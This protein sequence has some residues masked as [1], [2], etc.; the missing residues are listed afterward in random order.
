MATIT[1]LQ[2]AL[3]I[4]ADFNNVL[5]TLT[6]HDNTDYTE[7]Q[8]DPTEVSLLFSLSGPTG[9][10]YINTGFALDDISSPDISPI[11]SLDSA[12]IDLPL[13]TV[14]KIAPGTYIF[15]VKSVWNSEVAQVVKT[16]LFDYEKPVANI[17]M[18]ADVF[19][20]TITATDNT[21]YG[22][23]ASLGIT[24]II[25][26][27]TL[28]EIPDATLTG[29]VVTVGP[30]IW[31]KTWTDSVTSEVIWDDELWAQGDLVWI[32]IIDT[33][34]GEGGIDVSNS[35]IGSMYYQAYKTINDRLLSARGTRA[36]FEMD[37]LQKLRDD[38]VFYFG[39]YLLAERSGTD[40][41][42]AAS[43]IEELIQYEGIEIIV[44]DEPV[45]ILP[46]S[47]GS[48]T[49]VGTGTEW[50]SAPG[51][52]SPSVGESGDFYLDE[53][54]PNW[55]YKKIGGSWAK[56]LYMKGVTG[57][58]GP[59]GPTGVGATGPTGPT[60]ATG[61]SGPRGYL[62]IQGVPG[63]AGWQLRANPATILVPTDPYGY[64]GDYSK[65]SS[66]IELWDGNT[67]VDISGT[68]MAI[69]ADYLGVSQSVQS[70][71]SQK[72]RIFS[73]TGSY[74]GALV[75]KITTSF[76]YGGV[77][78][79]LEIPVLMLRAG[80]TG[81]AGPT[82]AAGIGTIGAQ[83]ITG[84]T[85]P[86]GASIVG[87]T[88]ARGATGPTGVGLTGPTGPTGA[89]GDIF[90]TTS[91]QSKAIPTSHPT[92]V[93]FSDV[94]AALKYSPGQEIIAAN[95][96]THYFV[97]TVTTYTGTTLTVSSV[98]NV[99]T[100]TFTAWAINMNGAP[101]PAGATGATGAAGPT[102]PTGAS[103]IG[104]TGPT[105]PTGIQGITGPTGPAGPTGV[106]ITGP[107]GPTG[108]T[109]A[110]GPTTVGPTGPTGP[111]SPVPGQHAA[112]APSVTPEYYGQW[113]HN[114]TNGDLYF[115]VG[116]TSADWHL[117]YTA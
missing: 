36:K 101:G 74:P 94:S 9:V 27:P 1:D 59:A 95:D 43:K 22:D 70:T 41:S 38:L 56:L 40:S 26:A 73:V 80:L 65:A 30:S 4:R 52:P 61:P 54:S 57:A 37:R 14:G 23:Y 102:G 111:A 88:G 13:N 46:I 20:S 107:T 64:S 106:G 83:G 87:P 113:Y 110:T 105:G 93:A 16:Y 6:I 21:E 50:F 103:V 31:T 7:L 85:G 108:A 98:S 49:V 39:L 78:K 82:G 90:A 112:G 10:Y 35:D 104:P 89:A 53:D 79:T 33:V 97:A 42:Y 29:K 55:L 114:D 63:V 2:S 17:D 75:L 19:A 28:S 58:T 91:A 24:H 15:N 84:P 47:G 34:N 71:G 81:P 32:R 3:R 48:S 99:G 68:S 96:S 67:Q 45:E 100:G 72:G 60:G 117:K 92:V 115:A 116:L 25:S 8:I 44:S 66:V 11:V 62:G 69:S 86:T 51:V 76:T 12:L 109:G 77:T 18:V 5:K